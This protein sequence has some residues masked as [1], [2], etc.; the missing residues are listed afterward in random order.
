[1]TAVQL[2]A[3]N[4]QIWRDMGIIAED[5]GMMRRVAKYI[6]KVAKE[7]TEDKTSMSKEEFYAMLDKR[8]EA[9]ARGEHS[10]MLPGE[11]LTEH[12]RRL[13]HDV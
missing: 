1:M 5:E 4:A 2:N 10:E 6:R 7:M 11:T 13:G 3:M 9:Y 12:L 8:E